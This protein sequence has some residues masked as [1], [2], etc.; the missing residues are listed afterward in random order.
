MPE[1]A[2]RTHVEYLDTLIAQAMDDAAITFRHLDGI[3]A[4]AGTGLI[5]GMIVG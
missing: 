5:G 1:I 2:A 4:T 3:A